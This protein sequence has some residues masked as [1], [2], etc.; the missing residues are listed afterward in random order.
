MHTHDFDCEPTIETELKYL[1]IILTSLKKNHE[2][3]RTILSYPKGDCL[4][5][6]LGLACLQVSL[7]LVC[8]QEK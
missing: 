5:F 3:F 8:I 4:F 1:K 7:L 6:R 2:Q